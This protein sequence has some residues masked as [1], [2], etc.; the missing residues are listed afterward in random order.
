[1]GIVGGK[2]ITTPNS[3]SESQRGSVYKQVKRSDKS[4]GS[5]GRDY[6]ELDDLRLE[7]VNIAGLESK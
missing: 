7:N 4:N 5:Y 1:M 6:T 2:S 3:P